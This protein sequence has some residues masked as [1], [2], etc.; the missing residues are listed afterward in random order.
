MTR[1]KPKAKAK[2]KAPARPGMIEN[3]IPVRGSREY[4]AWVR[5]LSDATL[6]PVAAIVRDALKSWAE[7]RGLPAPPR[8]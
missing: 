8:I 4:K 1:T 3:I 2:P 5:G 6:I 7:S